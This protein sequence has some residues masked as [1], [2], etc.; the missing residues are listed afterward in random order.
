MSAG[1]GSGGLDLNSFVFGAVVRLPV[2]VLLS[3][4]AIKI[5]LLLARTVTL[6]R[7]KTVLST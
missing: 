2:L 1:T 3:I 4:A 5:S 6:V 7:R